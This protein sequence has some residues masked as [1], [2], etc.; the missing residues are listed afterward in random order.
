MYNEILD[1]NGNIAIQYVSEDGQV[2]SVP[3][4]DSN[5]MYQEYLVWK[6]LQA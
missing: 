4:V 6:E 1:E 5:R 3:Q 2:W